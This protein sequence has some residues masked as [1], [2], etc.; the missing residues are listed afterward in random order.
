MVD[1]NK[2][3]KAQVAM[4]NMPNN[5]RRSRLSLLQASLNNDLDVL[6]LPLAMNYFTLLPFQVGLYTKPS[7]A[8]A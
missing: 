7:N 6:D 2:A 1:P 4:N 5:A 8:T 3:I